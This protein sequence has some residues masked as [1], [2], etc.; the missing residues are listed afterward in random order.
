VRMN[1]SCAYRRLVARI[2][3]IGCLVLGCVTVSV[4]QIVLR[5]SF[6]ARHF[7]PDGILEAGTI[8]RIQSLNGI[9]LVAGIALF[10]LGGV[11][12][13]W[14]RCRRWILPV[15]RFVQ[16]DL[17]PAFA[18]DATR[19]GRPD[20]PGMLI[21]VVLAAAL[22]SPVLSQAIR[23]TDGQKDYQWHIRAAET[24]ASSTEDQRV[25]LPHFLYQALVVAAKYVI[26][27][28]T[29]SQA[30]FLV[31]LLANGLLG[32]V[33]YV[34]IWPAFRAGGQRTVSVAAIVTSLALLVVTPI[35]LFTAA[36][37]DLY[38]GYIGITVYH[39]PTI[40]LLKPLALF[41]FLLVPGA[42]K[43]WAGAWR[44]SRTAVLGLL[45]GICTFAKP[46]Y[47]ICLLPAVAV[48]GLNRLIRRRTLGWLPVILGIG[49][50]SVLVLGWTYLFRY[51]AGDVVAQKSI[52]FAPFVVHSHYSGDLLPKFLLSILFPLYVLIG[53]WRGAR[54]DAFV[55][56]A[57]AA[58]V[59]GAFYGYL[60]AEVLPDGRI[61]LDANFFWSEQ[62]T[63]FILF[64][65]STR[66]FIR[67]E[68]L[69]DRG[70]KPIAAVSRLYIGAAVFLLHLAS[71]ALYYFVNLIGQGRYWWFAR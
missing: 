31:A 8:E 17:H 29:F 28:L 58:F 59:F 12:L 32:G 60:L 51:A 22:A 61:A 41:L 23:A 42:L 37:K 43:G 30:G 25:V 34:W 16:R 33:L 54:R 57:W 67:Q 15:A 44:R 18:Q 6:I 19:S 26:P 27:H 55:V 46:S 69:A 10:L 9:S 11:I 53:Y 7:S 20:L 36:R 13:A 64:V 4:S 49:L 5:A 50:P 68:R 24:L 2:I 3:A 1:R 35:T 21:T 47:A 48:A 14:R 65:A 40:T 39:N 38:L 45:S 56:L 66:L 70:E 63:L 52:A 71:G 62:I